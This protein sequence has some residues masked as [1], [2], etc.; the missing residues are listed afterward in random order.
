M[1]ISC[2]THLVTTLINKTALKSRFYLAETPERLRSTFGSPTKLG[3]YF[4]YFQ[5]F[6]MITKLPNFV[7]TL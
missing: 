3:D 5:I 6:T 4:N 7:G 1:Q 2:V